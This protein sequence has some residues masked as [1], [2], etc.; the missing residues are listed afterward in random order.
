MP[1]AAAFGG[2]SFRSGPE[3]IGLLIALGAG[4][5]AVAYTLFFRGL[6]TAAASTAALLALL[7]PLTGAILAALILGQRLTATGIAGA[8]IL[9]A[10]VIVT[11]RGANGA[12]ER[13]NPC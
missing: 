5:T 8:A 10:A 12:P 9:V 7:E 11:V 6:R 1:L 4:P 2:L 3:A 13:V